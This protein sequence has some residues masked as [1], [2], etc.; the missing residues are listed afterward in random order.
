V[1]F[2]D[3]QDILE[4]GLP[5]LFWGTPVFYSVGMAPEFLRPILAANPLS[6]FLGA[7][8]SALLDGRIPSS[9]QLG[10]AA[11]SVAVMLVLGMWVFARHQPRFAEEL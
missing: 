6:S 2:L 10:L 11:A 4:V 3:T 9:A 7:V 5:M 8:R 1:F